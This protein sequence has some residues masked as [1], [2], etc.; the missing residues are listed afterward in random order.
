MEKQENDNLE[1]LNARRAKRAQSRKKSMAVVQGEVCDLCEKNLATFVKGCGHVFCDNCGVKDSAVCILCGEESESTSIASLLEE[2]QHMLSSVDLVPDSKDSLESKFTDILSAEEVNMMKKPMSPDSRLYNHR[3]IQV[4]WQDLEYVVKLGPPW[5]K[6]EKQVLYPMTGFCNPGEMLAIMGPSGSGKTSLL[7]ILAQRVKHTDGSIFTNGI[8]VTKKFKSVSAYVTQDD[9][10]NGK[11]TVMEVLIFTAM[12]KIPMMTPLREKLK[13][14][15]DILSDL[16][17]QRCKRTRIGIPGVSKGVSGGERK[18]V[19]IAVELLNSPSV[20]FIDEPTSGLDAKTALGLTETIIRLSRQ[21]RTMI[22][23]IH[24]PRSDIFKLFDK[25]L[26][27]SG[28]KPVF[29]GPSKDAVGHLAKLGFHLPYGYNPGDFLIDLVTEVAN[30]GSEF[31]DQKTADRERIKKIQ[32]YNA[33]KKVVIPKPEFDFDLNHGHIPKYPT[34]YFN[35]FFVLFVREFLSV[36]RDTR[37]TAA[38]LF[39]IIIFALAAGFMYMGIGNNQASIQDRKGALFFVILNMVMGSMFGALL[40][41]QQ[42]K[43]VFNRERSSKTYR[44]SSYFLAKLAAE[45]PNICFMPILYSCIAYYMIGLQPAAGKF[46]TFMGVL[47]LLN[48][49]TQALGSFMSVSAPNLGVATTIS[50]LVTVVLQLFGG[51][52]FNLT[53]IPSWLIWAPFIDIYT[54]SYESL[55]LN[56]FTGLTFICDPGEYVGTGPTKVCP[57]TN[58]EEV[59]DSMA[60]GTQLIWLNCIMVFAIFI[61]YKIFSYLFLRFFH[62]AR[63]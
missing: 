15:N 23:T 59:L 11:L 44:V 2:Q 30:D 14:V 41:F 6:Y 42:G 18:R 12:L 62:K 26:L 29:F 43:E 40:D 38:R 17:L 50:P 10:L 57:I 19:S 3:P 47:I 54:Y 52:Y 37:L 20:L 32:D 34:S 1:E 27:L 53:N 58:G 7:N 46:F 55:C 35:E 28:G 51:F 24:Q 45:T 25:L 49:A 60:M 5:K 8:Y 48:A 56:E 13:K 36:I 61:V 16:G 4:S 22:M 39:Q 21:N 63:V 33:L 9:I 31:R